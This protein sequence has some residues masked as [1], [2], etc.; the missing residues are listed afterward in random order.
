[1]ETS[2]TIC[3]TLHEA[4]EHRDIERMLSLYA[5]NAELKVVDRDHPPSHPLE[6]RGKPAIEGYLRDIFGRDMTHRV[7]DEVVGED[8]LSFTEDC[9]YGD[10]THVFVSSTINLQG[11]KIAR[12]VEVQAWDETPSH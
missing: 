6:L 12:E 10:G 7:L 2:A 8:R 4:I 11:D 9:T 3:S 5:D 1:M